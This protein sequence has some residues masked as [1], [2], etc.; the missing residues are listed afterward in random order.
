MARIQISLYSPLPLFST[1][2][3]CSEP[4]CLASRP[5]PALSSPLT[6][7]SKV[8]TRASEIAYLLLQTLSPALVQ[9]HYYGLLP[10]LQKQNL[11]VQTWSC[12]GKHLP[13]GILTFQVTAGGRREALLRFTPHQFQANLQHFHLLSFTSCFQNKFFLDDIQSR[14][15]VFL[16]HSSSRRET[17]SS[18][19]RG[20]KVQKRKKA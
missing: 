5:S 9:T 19:G 11:N 17:G 18:R 20:G 3:L 12:N 7:Q 2:S 13:R 6:F 1:S 14:S 8:T 4:V 10:L 16:Q 15:T